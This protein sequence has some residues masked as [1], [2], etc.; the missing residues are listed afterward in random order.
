MRPAIVLLLLFASS[1]GLGGS[2]PPLED[3]EPY[4]VASGVY[5]TV[6]TG[7]AEDPTVFQTATDHVFTV[8]RD[9]DTATLSFE[10]EDG[11][12]IEIRYTSVS[13]EWLF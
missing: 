11:R 8:D 6:R 2:C 10:T 12:A 5:S 3:L 13:E 9:A 1:C 7:S 4:P